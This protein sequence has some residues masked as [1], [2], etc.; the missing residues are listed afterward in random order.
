MPREPQHAAAEAPMARTA[1]Y[2]D[3]IQL[4]LAH[5][6]AQRGVAARIF[7]RRELLPHRIAV[8]RCVAHIGERQRLIE[9]APHHVPW[10][11]PDARRSD[12]RADVHEW[13]SFDRNGRRSRATIL[14][15][16]MSGGYPKARTGALP[17]LC[18]IEG[19]PV[20]SRGCKANIS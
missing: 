9:L 10:L 17:A 7:G 20:H 13:A 11:R 4:V 8:I 1:G 5:L 2:D 16:T 6:P 12:L 15:Y 19:A 18:D 14:A 3:G